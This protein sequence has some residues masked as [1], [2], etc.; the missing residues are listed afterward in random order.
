MVA[1]VTVSLL[2]LGN[3]GIDEIR[4]LYK[5]ISLFT[6][7]SAAF[8]VVKR[9][10]GLNE[11]TI[12]IFINI[13]F[14]VSFIQ[15]FIKSDF[16]F[17]LVSGARTS[18][19]RGVPGL[20]SEPSFYGFMVI[21][22]F[23]FVLDF[24]KHR[25]LY[26]FNLL[27]Q[28]ILFAQSSVSMVYAFIYLLILVVINLG[29]FRPD[30]FLYSIGFIAMILVLLFLF[31]TDIQ[32]TRI[33]NIITRIIQSPLKLYQTDGSVRSRVD[34]IIIPI[35]ESFSSY[36]LPK[37]F[38]S[39]DFYRIMSGYGAAIYELGFISLIVIG[40]IFYVIYSAYYHNNRKLNA[41]FITII[42][43]SA[44]QLSTPILPFYLG[45]CLYLAKTY[46]SDIKGVKKRFSDKN[47]DNSK[48][49]FGRV[50]TFEQ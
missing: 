33:Y 18:I 28:L 46:K 11:K 1:V 17:F 37:G 41:I 22:M 21:F 10:N 7:S 39:S 3:T 6:I 40:N 30:F 5:Y 43:F 25:N 42:M 34:D 8:L 35:Q 44:I 38:A 4:S 13:W 48:Y 9:N 16:L 31:V 26:I 19:N 23:L 20:T 36:L 15:T 49:W 24:K 29:K 2:L 47:L 12:K 45:Y 27:I 32:D 50:E 14:L